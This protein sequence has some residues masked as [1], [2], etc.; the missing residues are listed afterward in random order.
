[1]F[2]DVGTKAHEVEV[3]VPHTHHGEP[4]IPARFHPHNV[5]TS[6]RSKPQTETLQAL[7][8]RV[9]ADLGVS[10]AKT[11]AGATPTGLA[12][13]DGPAITD[14][15]QQEA[16]QDTQ[17]EVVDAAG[18]VAVAAVMMEHSVPNPDIRPIL[19]CGDPPHWRAGGWPRA[20]PGQQRAPDDTSDDG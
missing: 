18:G 2:T 13:G 5:L 11:V 7:I 8:R 9:M 14:E 3:R 6:K 4:H 16:E 15:A 17:E 20:V 10:V 1:M 19:T 12:T